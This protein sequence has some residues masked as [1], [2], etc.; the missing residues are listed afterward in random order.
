MRT[1]SHPGISAFARHPVAAAMFVGLLGWFGQGSH[2]V[3]QEGAGAIIIQ[4]IPRFIRGDANRDGRVDVADASAIGFSFTRGAPPFTCPDAA[5]VDDNGA[6][7]GPSPLGA[8]P[9]LAQ[10]MLVLLDA[11]IS[12]SDAVAAPPLPAPFPEFG[13][14]LAASIV[15]GVRRGA[16]RPRARTRTLVFIG[17]IPWCWCR[18]RPV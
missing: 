17:P 4:P 18:A 11:L 7:V 5:D 16:H 15:S 3:A 6:L 12:T 8:G 9:P 14:D 10:D 13:T 1:A 2:L